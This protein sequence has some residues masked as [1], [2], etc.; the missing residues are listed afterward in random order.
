MAKIEEIVPPSHEELNM[1]P[2]SFE[3]PVD[4][5]TWIKTHKRLLAS[6]EDCG[7][8]IKQVLLNN[9]RLVYREN[10]FDDSQFRYLDDDG[11]IA[12]LDLDLRKVKELSHLVDKTGKFDPNVSAHVDQELRN[13][14][15]N[16]VIRNQN[17]IARAMD[18][19]VFKKAEKAAVA[20]ETVKKK[21]FTF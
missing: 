18:R 2:E 20:H 9:K 1:S 21:E 10:P 13:L 6:F 11:N 16:P 12:K 4:L 7:V 3:D 8:E 19:V 15:F 14:G 5:A 17:D